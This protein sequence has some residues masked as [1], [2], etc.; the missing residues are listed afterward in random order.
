MIE[1]AGRH[2]TPP[3]EI[4][5]PNPTHYYTP[6]WSPDSKK[7]LYTDTNLNVWVLDVA[8]GQAKIVGNDPWMVPQRTLNPVVEPG[9]EVGRVLEPPATRST[10]RSSSQR[11][12][13]RDE[14]GDR[15]SGRRD[16]AGVGRE[17]QVPL[18][19][20]VDR[21][22]PAV[23]VA[24]HDVVRPHR[25]LR[26]VPRGA[27]EG[28]ADA[29][30]AGE[31]RG[32]GRRQRRRRRSRRGGGRGARRRRRPATQPRLDRPRRRGPRAARAGD[33]A[34]R[35][36]RPA[37]AH[38]RDSRRAGAR[39]LAAARG[40]GRARSTTSKP[41]AAGGGRRR[42]RRQHAHAVPAERSPRGAVRRGRRPSTTSAPT[43]TSCSIAPAAAAAAGAAARAAA[44]RHGRAL[45][46]RRRSQRAAAGAGRLNATLRMYLEPKEEFKQIFNEGWRNQRDY[47][48]VP[49]MHGTDWAEDREMYGKLLP[50]VN[51][52]AD[53][54]YLLDIMGAEIAIGHSYVRGGDMPE[55]PT[56]S[57]GGLLGADFAIE[58][59]RYKITRIYDNESWNPD[60][61]APLAAPGV[62]VNVGDYILAI[63]GVELKAPDNIY[64]L[65]DGTGEPADRAHG[66][67]AA[68]AGRRAPGD[69]RA[70][71]ERAGAAHARVGRRQPPS[72]RQAVERPARLR[73]PAEHRAARLHELQPLLLRAA[74]QEGRRRR[75][76][77]QR[78]RLGG[79]L[80]HRRACSATSTATSTTSPAIASR[81]R[82]RRPASGD[83][84]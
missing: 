42:R 3:R 7:L 62:D 64:R 11:R 81:S 54:N 60:L 73:L 5:L 18:V 52:R 53:L 46:R 22:R 15:R 70:G 75:R 56:R 84:R 69:G 17:R 1:V 55:V 40:R 43:A 38:P 36:R 2:S 14:A 20:R 83:R 44:P 66:R 33:G 49:N 82:V 10:T 32:H 8:S 77:L 16:V 63:N 35:L 31:R 68:G 78:R 61:R 59:G 34:D 9:L 48:Y 71:R 27:E 39:V 13:R 29:A 6:S 65:L 79:R 19:P 58:S 45:P 51:H 57:G 30:A 12:D 72:R 76:A 80:H 23:A 24:R 47:L 21:L 25:E 41:A 26:S 37:A 67:T 50:Y 4:A 74:G 28:R